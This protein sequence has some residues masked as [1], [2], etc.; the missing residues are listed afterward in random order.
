[1]HST[2]DKKEIVKQLE[3]IN[4]EFGIITAN[5]TILKNYFETLIDFY[6]DKKYFE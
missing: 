3:A 1:M 4:K 6:K 5:M 2:K